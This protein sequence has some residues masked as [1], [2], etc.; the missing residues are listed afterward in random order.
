MLVLLAVLIIRTL[1]AASTGKTPDPLTVKLPPTFNVPPIPTPPATVNAPVVE[2]ILVV[3]L[4]IVNISGDVTSVWVIVVYC[5][6]NWLA[7]IVPPTYK[8]PPIPTPPN[9]VSAPVDVLV[10]LVELLILTVLVVVPE[11]NPV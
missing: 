8:L 2:L 9:T 11:K 1:P 3:V 7:V 6:V 4:V 5:I 10:E